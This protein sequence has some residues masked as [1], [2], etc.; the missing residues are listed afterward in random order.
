MKHTNNIGYSLPFPPVAQVVFEDVCSYAHKIDQTYQDAHVGLDIAVSTQV[1]HTG[2]VTNVQ[3]R[4]T[5]LWS[6]NQHS[7]DNLG[8]LEGQLVERKALA[9]G[10]DNMLARV[11]DRLY[12][13]K[14]ARR[15]TMRGF[16]F[17]FAYFVAGFLPSMCCLSLFLHLLY[18]VN[19]SNSQ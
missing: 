5:I 1:G 18:P 19:N 3:E 13:A 12:D 8:R 16:L 6:V 7:V 4:L 15:D 9:T 10:R 2:N 11:L 14:H 17:V